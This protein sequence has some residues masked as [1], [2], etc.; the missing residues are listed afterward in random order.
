VVNASNKSNDLTLEILIPNGTK[1]GEAYRKIN[2]RRPDRDEL[3]KIR[4]G[5]YTYDEF[6]A[7]ANDKLFAV[8]EAFDNCAL[9]EQPDE[10]VVNGLLGEMRA[11]WYGQFARK[12]VYR[13]QLRCLHYL[14]FTK[15]GF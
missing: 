10:K 4:A 11:V 6:V 14:C 2:V 7:R 9:P 5:H 1:N 3:L 13:R 12:S 15:R 8:K